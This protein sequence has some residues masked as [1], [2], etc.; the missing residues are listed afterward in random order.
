MACL[1][2]LLQLVL[3]LPPLLLLFLV[4]PFFLILPDSSAFVGFPAMSLAHYSP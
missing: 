3:R 2:S 4:L 1:P